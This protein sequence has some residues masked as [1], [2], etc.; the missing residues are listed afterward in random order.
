M[1]SSHC[2][3]KTKMNFCRRSVKISEFALS[4]LCLISRS[5][6][7]Y[8]SNFSKIRLLIL[9]YL[10]ILD[11]MSYCITQIVFYLFVM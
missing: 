11:R 6:V 10:L 9:N 3:F 4:V 5:R 8:K 7:S 2:A 1:P